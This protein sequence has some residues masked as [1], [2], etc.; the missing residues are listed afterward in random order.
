M[1][2]L[3]VILIINILWISG[4]ASHKASQKEQMGATMMD[5]YTRSSNEARKD[6]AQFIEHHLKEQKTFGYVKPYIP[7]VNEPVVRKVWI[8]DHKSEDNA[9]TMIAGHWTY[10][11]IRPATWFIDEKTLENRIPVTIPLAS[12]SFKEENKNAYR[13]SAIREDI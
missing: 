8:P 6:V 1:D 3:K 9:D 4:C 13:D 10:L 2:W 12:A 5:I 11:M 7:I